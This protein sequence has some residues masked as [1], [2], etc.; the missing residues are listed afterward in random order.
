RAFPP[1]AALWVLLLP[2]ADCV[3]LMSRR[4]RA[5]RSPFVA[6][7]R[8]IHHYL[9]AMGFTH[10]QA[11]ATLVGLSALFGAVGYFGWRWG[12]PEPMLFWPFFFGFFAY[13]FWIKAQWKNIERRGAGDP[14]ELPADEP[15]KVA[16]AA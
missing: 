13:H 15:D 3:S 2:L 14:C 11:L 8:H 16:P 1:I 6:D 4:V 9:L 10:G 7:R 12:V 5:R